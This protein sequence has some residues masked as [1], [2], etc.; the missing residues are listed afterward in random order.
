[1]ERQVYEFI[2]AQ[3]GE[4][5]VERRKC[6]V[7]GQEF[8][9]TDKDLEFYSKISPVFKGSKYEIPAP[10]LCPDCRQ[11]RR[12]ARRSR[13]KLYKRKC[14]ATGKTIISMFSPDGW[15]KVYHTKIWESDSW[16]PKDYWMDFDFT[17]SF[18]EQFD[19]LLKNT[20]LPHLAIIEATLE[21]SD[22]V[23]WAN[24]VKNSYLS[25]NLV[26]SENVYYSE[27]VYNSDNCV[28]C[29]SLTKSANCF[30]CV[31]SINLYNCEYLYECE[32][33]RDS[34]YLEF[35]K[36][37]NNCI[38][39]VWLINKQYCIFNNQYTEQEYKDLAE[40]LIIQEITQ[41]I[42][43]LRLDFPYAYAKII[44]SEN[45]F[46]NN[47]INSKNITNS[48]DISNSE[49]IKD[50]IFVVDNSKDC[51]DI[52]FWGQN[53][54]LCY[55]WAAIWLSSNKVLFSAE[56]YDNI[57]NAYYCYFCYPNCSNIF[58]CVWLRNAEFCILNK[59]YTKEEYE[60]L[61]PK[62][63]EYMQKTLERWEF[64]PG[65]ISPFGYNETADNEYFPLSR[66]E[67]IAKW[68]KWQDKEYPINVP[69]WIELVKWQDLPE[70]I[71]DVDDEILKKAVICEVSWK[72]FRIVKP[73]LEFYRKHWLSLPRKHPDI[74]YLRRIQKKPQKSLYLRACSNCSKQVISVYPADSEFRI[75]CQDCYNKE[76][77]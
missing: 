40:K 67:A 9:I 30:E 56:T 18:F 60:N 19:E 44:N 20:P 75:Y 28:D 58:G 57:K 70:N 48:F 17:R 31:S 21:N 66:D 37:C 2:A 26:N 8:T 49:N 72:P 6:P 36:W 52:S 53:I 14:D 73:E 5:I 55:E 33:C 59:Q 77:Y 74:R 51:H 38:G 45:A 68:F 10:T 46:G 32:D 64:F 13:V 34:I 63:I 25:S 22:Y 65:S 11:Q 3:T 76:N 42:E 47:I 1:M 16:N 43:K 15:Y 23:N 62:I 12:L 69:D 29:L 27:D 7:C 71:N 41:H 24:S 39:C 35:C 54:S 4:K 50:S 61:V